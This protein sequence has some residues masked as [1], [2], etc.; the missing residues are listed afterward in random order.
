ME[1]K[2]YTQDFIFTTGDSE[3]SSSEDDDE[4]GSEEADERTSTSRGINL[5]CPFNILDSFHCVSG[6][7]LDLM[8]DCF[9]GK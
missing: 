1:M 4:S 8:H 3:G 2:F 6:F 5:Q 7:P 9:E